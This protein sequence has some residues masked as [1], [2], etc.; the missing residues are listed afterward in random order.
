M[1]GNEDQSFSAIKTPDK[2]I[3]REPSHTSLKK[4]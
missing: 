4:S 1:P 3:H 2:Y